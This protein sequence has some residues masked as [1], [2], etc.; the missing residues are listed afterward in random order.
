[1]DAKSCKSYSRFEKKFDF[2]KIVGWLHDYTHRK[3]MEGY[4]GILSNSK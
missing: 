2:I 3:V 4:K 1:M